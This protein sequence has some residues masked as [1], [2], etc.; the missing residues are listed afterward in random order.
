MV[1]LIELDFIFFDWMYLFRFVVRFVVMFF[2]IFCYIIL[3]IRIFDVIEGVKI[4][5]DLYIVL[6]DDGD[7]VI[8]MVFVKSI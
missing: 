3:F 7:R 1:N 6:F 5:F 8:V 2:E 4:V